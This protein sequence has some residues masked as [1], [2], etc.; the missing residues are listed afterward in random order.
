MD[1]YL[2]M[3]N[4]YYKTGYIGK[5]K[6]YNTDHAKR[7]AWAIASKLNRQ[8]TNAP[9]RQGVEPLT[10]QPICCQLKLF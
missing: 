5:V 6:P 8:T 3:I 4:K 1:I 10:A 2:N 7:I 9:R